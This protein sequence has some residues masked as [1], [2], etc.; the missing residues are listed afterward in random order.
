MPSAAAHELTEFL[1][2]ALTGNPDSSLA[3]RL[4]GQQTE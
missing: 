2:S 4:T 3:R 1:G